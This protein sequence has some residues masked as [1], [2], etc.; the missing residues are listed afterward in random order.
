VRASRSRDTEAGCA[1]GATSVGDAYIVARGIL[2]LALL[3]ATACSPPQQDARFRVA[4]ALADF[5]EHQR[6]N[7]TTDLVSPPEEIGLDQL[8]HGWR[9]EGTANSRKSHAEI[10]TRVGR[11]EVFS[12]DG[13]LTGLEI[14]LALSDG[15][16]KPRQVNVA[17]NGRVL[18][19]LWVTGGW[20]TH[21]V[22]VPG[23]LVRT[24]RNILELRT[25][26]VPKA[27][28]KL[29][30]VRLR[31]LRLES[32]SGR[33]VW[34]QRPGTIRTLDD[35]SEATL[36]RVVEMPT[37]S[38]V[39]V[40]LEVPHGAYL[41]GELEVTPATGEE[42]ESV[43]AYV[44]LLDR[45]QSEK[46]LA[47][48]HFERKPARRRKLAVSLTPWSGQLVRLRFGITGSSNAVLRWHG[49][50]VRGSGPVAVAAPRPPID[51]TLPERTGRLGQPDVLVILLD[52]ARADAF[53]PYDGPYE[54]PATERLAEDGT[55]FL[56]ALAPAPWTGQSV[57]AMLTGLHSDVLG[58]DVW[59]SRLPAEVATL[60]ELML[61]AG[62]LTVLW[63]QHPLYWT[64]PGLERG[65]ERAHHS[66]ET[67]YQV[68]PSA[69]ELLFDDRPTFAFVH[70]M[71]PHLPYTPPAPH[72]GAYS[73]WYEGEMAV[74]AESLGGYSLRRERKKLSEADLRYVR[75]RYQ[76][77]VAF[78]DALLGRVLDL[79]DRRNRYSDALVVLLSDHGEA[80]LEHGRFKHGLDVHREMLHVP[81]V[82]KWPSAMAGFRSVVDEP[83]SLLDLVPSLV[84]GLGL[85]AGGH[86]FQGRSLLPLA[87]E[88]RAME[89]ALYA[90]TR[91]VLLHPEHPPRPKLM[92][93]L[94]NWR[95]LYDPLAER[96]RLYRADRDPLERHD[97]ASEEPLRALLLRQSLLIQTA[98]NRRLRESWDSGKGVEGLAPETV[99]QL[100]R[101]GYVN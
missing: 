100:R 77:N 89:R 75:D 96:S 9:I 79:L 22:D 74:D 25:G 40:V 14:E 24:G 85:S 58:V 10:A 5:V 48:M 20:T 1:E 71:P 64:S 46:R 29:P 23:E 57:P 41:G 67:T 87:F 52:A 36:E 49:V 72:R 32:K 3:L 62:Y 86:G 88:G 38:H 21:R 27:S 33:P 59:G 31:R 11:I 6:Y 34:L 98:W 90:R 12:S 65:F 66:E 51:C 68:L 15:P 47:H 17:V 82:V 78:A 42:F 26:Y 28:D 13:D 101:L 54:T 35:G 50:G 99:E 80:F 92:L 56:N 69:K 16:P 43:D 4:L 63:S 8:V 53:S 94:G 7:L 61:S 84:D 81:L 95:L 2:A 60:A 37:A 45:E 93:E 83:V 97:L 91:G 18:G 73:S 44:H 30:P 70:L 39:D 19:P 76:E 55:V